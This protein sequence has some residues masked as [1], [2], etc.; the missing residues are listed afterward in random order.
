MFDRNHK[1]GSFTTNTGRTLLKPDHIFKKVLAVTVA[2]TLGLT[3]STPSLANAEE[4]LGGEQSSDSVLMNDSVANTDATQSDNLTDATQSDGLEIGPEIVGQPVGAVKN[5]TVNHVSVGDKT[6][7]GKLTIGANQ[8]KKRELDVTIHVTVNRQAGGTEEKTVTIPYTTKSQNWSVTLDSELVADDEV[9]VKQEA[10]GEISEGVVLEVKESLKDQ[11]KDELKMPSGEIWIEQAGAANIVNEEEQA[12][13]LR[14]VKEANPAIADDIKSV[15][16]KIYGTSQ[17]KMAK[18]NVT[19][20]DTTTSG[21]IEAPD[22]TVKQVTETSS[23]A[24]I[25]DITVVDNEIK[26]KLQGDGPF[27]GIKVQIFLRISSDPEKLANF[28]SENGCKVD[29]DS[30]DPVD[31]NVDSATGEFTYTISSAKDLN[32]DQIVGVSVKEKNKFVSCGTSTVKLATPQK[33]EVRDPKKLTDADKKAI[34]QAIRDANTVDGVSKL[35]DGTGDREGIPAVIKIDESGNARIFSG[36]SV[37]GDW[38]PDNGWKFVPEKDEDGSYKIKEGTKPVFVIPAKDLVKNGAPK[39]PSIEVDTNT[40]TVTITPPAYENPGEDT[41]LASYIFTYTNAS[42]AEKTVT[43]TRNVDKDTWTANNATVDANTGVITLRVE[44]IEV[45]GTI[46]ATA[47]DNGGLEGD[48]EKLD[49]DEASTTLETAT[50][51]YDANNGTGE[52]DGKKLNKGS[53]YKI[54]RNAFTAPDNEKF[55]TWKIGE[56]E[57]AADD[58]ITVKED[59]SIQAVWQDIEVKVSYDPNGGSGEMT[60]KTLKKGSKYTLLE[61]SFKAP[62]E[63]QEFK[64]WEV[65]GEEVAPGAEITVND[66]TVVKAL[67]KKSQVSVSY[68]G[69]GGS[70]EMATETVDKGSKYTLLESSFKAPD[71]NQEFK[72]WEVDGKEVPAGTEITVNDDTV[73]KAVWKKIQVKV[74][75]DANGGEG[76]MEGKTLDKGDTYKVLA[77]TFTAPENY[78][79]KAWEV[80]GEEVAPDTEITVDKDTVVK[81]VWKRIQVKVSY[82]GNG[83]SGEMAAVTVGKGSKYAVLPNGFTAPD[84]NQEFKAWEVNGEEVAPGT[85]ITVNDDTVVKALWKKSQVD[86]PNGGSNNHSDGTVDASKPRNITKLPSTGYAGMPYQVAAMMI[87]AAGGLVIAGWKRTRQ[88]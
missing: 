12:E 23:A 71:E 35:P 19:Y 22:L 53:K 8:R 79:F 29:K 10:G 69:N 30:S 74:S 56:T 31:V 59:T 60:G 85:E 49:S 33:T 46:K 84:E 4:L 41:D 83:G 51:S 3:L 32:Y 15:E 44:D 67:W 87:L 13:A 66:D 70:G 6:V 50:V 39:S 63:T 43:A 68:D 62:D 47:K 61:S 20:T 27:A 73:V 11:H 64:A 78:E 24:E 37:A 16:L 76:T 9:T 65:N 18:I 54:L 34:D 1:P 42:G 77:S 5:P 55:R 38:D 52:M 48:T 7:S 28:S 80:D 26:G 86:N 25:S 58:E 14:L 75:Y 72:A 57:Y 21:E 2:C 36:N 81:A 17:P 40:G 45:G 82:D 88:N